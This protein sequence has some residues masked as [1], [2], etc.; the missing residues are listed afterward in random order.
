MEAEDSSIRALRLLLR[1]VTILSE[2]MK[3][4]IDILGLVPSRYDVRDG[5]TVSS[6]L[7]AFRGMGEPPVIAEIKKRE[8][9]GELHPL[10]TDF[11]IA[12]LADSPG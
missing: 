1:Q 2:E 4:D 5:E 7:E 11:G 9:G 6:M 12:R 10:L 3:A 8:S